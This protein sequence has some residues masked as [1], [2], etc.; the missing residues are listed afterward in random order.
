MIAGINQVEP[1]TREERVSQSSY[2]KYTYLRPILYL[3]VL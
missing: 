2:F 3:L 1:R